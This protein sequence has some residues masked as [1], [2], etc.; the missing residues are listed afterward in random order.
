MNAFDQ[1]LKWL[2]DGTLSHT[3]VQI[4]YRAHVRNSKVFPDGIKDILG[5]ND[6][7]SSG[8]LGLAFRLIGQIQGNMEL[9]YRRGYQAGYEDAKK[10]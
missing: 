9:A 10:E 1:F 5:G 4:A 3:M 7:G 2:D 6:S 8:I